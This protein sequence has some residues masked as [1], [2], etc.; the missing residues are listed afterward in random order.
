MAGAVGEQVAVMQQGRLVEWGRTA[1]VFQSPSDPY[2]KSLLQ[3]AAE[4]GRLETAG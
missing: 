3:A 2:T 1:E 4:V